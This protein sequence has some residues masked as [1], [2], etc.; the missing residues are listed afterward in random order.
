MGWFRNVLNFFFSNLSE[1]AINKL[2][3]DSD[4]GAQTT[5]KTIEKSKNF[6]YK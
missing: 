2:T 1:G 4:S 6:D 3:L 5:F